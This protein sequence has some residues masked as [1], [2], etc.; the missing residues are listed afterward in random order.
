M[1]NAEMV[2]AILDGQGDALAGAYDRYAPALYGYCRGLLGESAAAGG[3]VQDTFIV[4]VGALGGLREPGRLRPWLYAVTRNECHRRLRARASTVPPG[5]AG[6]P[7]EDTAD[8]GAHGE[9]AELRA[10][11]RAA[12][13]GLD[14]GDREIA[15]LNLRHDLGGQDLADVLGVSVSQAEALVSRATARFE[16]ALGR[17]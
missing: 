17:C 13:A 1:Q 9:S 12:L 10:I 11:V 4:A 16:S 7:G 3:A 8:L 14:P 15:E 2:D 6:G 5:A